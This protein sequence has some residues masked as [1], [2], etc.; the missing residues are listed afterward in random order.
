MVD[1]D[2]IIKQIDALTLS[3]LQELFRRYG[4][5]VRLKPDPLLDYGIEACSF[6]QEDLIMASIELP[7]SDPQEPPCEL[8]VACNSIAS[9]M[10][11]KEELENFVEWQQE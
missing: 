3:E 7:N 9:G 11:V 2:N 10:R 5:D 4:L 1:Y 6:N 8:F